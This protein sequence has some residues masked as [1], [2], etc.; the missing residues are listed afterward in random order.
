MPNATDLRR[1]VEA[2]RV[3][4]WPADCQ[5]IGR[6][7]VEAT[8]PASTPLLLLRPRNLKATLFT[9]NPWEFRKRY[10]GIVQRRN[11]QPI[12]ADRPMPQ[13]QQCLMPMV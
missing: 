6:S 3:A 1:R 5:V 8:K 12:L 10:M 7:S 11:P 9:K 4:A 2:R 13:A